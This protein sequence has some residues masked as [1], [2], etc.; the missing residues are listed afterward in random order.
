MGN[1]FMGSRK[2]L[3]HAIKKEYLIF[4]LQIILMILMVGYWQYKAQQPMRTIG[5][6]LP[7]WDSQG[8]TWDGKWRMEKG[9]AA[10]L[11]SPY[12]TIPKGTYTLEV[13]YESEQNENFEMT[14]YENMHVFLHGGNLI[15]NAGRNVAR[16]DFELDQGLDNVLISMTS[17]GKG[18]VCLNDIRI[19]QNRNDIGQACAVLGIVFLLLDLFWVQWNVWRWKKEFLFG[20]Y[21]ILLFASLPLMIPGIYIGMDIRFHYMRLEGL[22]RELASGHFPVRVQSA[23]FSGFGYPVS[24][25]YGDF[26]LYPAAILRMMGMPL[27]KA[28]KFHLFMVNYL[29]V[30]SSAICFRRITRSDWKSLVLTCIYVL[31][32]YRLFDVY[33]RAGIGEMS[34]FIFY[35]IIALG[36][37]ETICTKRFSFADALKNGSYLAVGVSGIICSHMLS[38]EITIVVLSIACVLYLRELWSKQGIKTLCVGAVLSLLLSAFFVIPFLSMYQEIK[39]QING[40]LTGGNGQMIQQL[41]A[42]WGQYFAFTEKI[43]GYSVE[44]TKVRFALTPGAS[45]MCVFI[46]GIYVLFLGTKKERIALARPMVLAFL[47]LWLSSDRFPWNAL[48]LRTKIGRI[49]AQIQFPWRYLCPALILLTIIMIVLYQQET[50]DRISKPV[51]IGLVILSLFFTCDYLSQY[52]SNA[53]ISN[54]W[55]MGEINNGAAM[56][57]EYWRQDVDGERLVPRIQTTD[58]VTAGILEQR[59]I[60]TVL[61]CTAESD[62]TIVL[63]Q[64]SYG[65]MQAKDSTGAYLETGENENH[66]VMIT[67]PK[68]FAGQIVCDYQE[69]ILWVVGN[70]VSLVALIAIGI[71]CVKNNSEGICFRQG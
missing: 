57:F 22:W 39:V 43:F 62:G 71:L 50:F 45:L 9:Q 63:P 44:E 66:Q 19:V 3:N 24:L 13:E 28:Y 27:V 55:D 23:W 42:Y 51:S 17:S 33:T 49:M 16:T 11:T 8:I 37:Y 70:G 1:A 61:E 40:S 48:A 46:A 59:G 65:H 67:V 47:T 21:G 4:I 53:D 29:T 30:L 69:P 52:L 58:G 5:V 14:A 38:G 34:G 60:Q 26:L 64:I 10:T 68:G 25:Y 56:N 41:G 18:M 2:R 35:P 32:N 6:S 12:L 54:A 31:A 36:M 7:L 15:L 20:F